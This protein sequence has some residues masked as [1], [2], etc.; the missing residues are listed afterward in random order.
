MLHVLQ[1]LLLKEE[2]LKM[3]SGLHWALSTKWRLIKIQ[4]K[5]L[6]PRLEMSDQLVYAAQA[7][8]L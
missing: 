2:E 3:V 5:Q 7:S 6:I 1:D 8:Y 4:E